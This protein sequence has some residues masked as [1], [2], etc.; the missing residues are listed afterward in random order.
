MKILVTGGA[1]YVGSVLVPYLLNKGHKVCVL[2]ILTHGINGLFGCFNNKNF[3][4]RKGDVRNGYEYREALAGSVDA[5]IHLAAVVGYP[6]CKQ[7]KDV[8]ISIN[9]HG[10]KV[11]AEET[12]KELPIIFASTGSVYG[13]IGD[14]CTEDVPINPLTIYGE[15]KG[16]AETMFKKRGNC[17]ILRF[18]TAYGVSPRMRLDLMINDFCYKAIHHNHLIVYERNFRRTFIHVYDMARA[19]LFAIENFDSMA[20][21]I[22]NVGS[23]NMN[24]TKKYIVEF[25]MQQ[26]PYYLHY[27]DIGEDEDKRD[28]AVSYEKIDALG[29]Q[30][31]VSLQ[32]GIDQLISLFEVW[33]IKSKYSNV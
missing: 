15:S 14:M 24:L 4:F 25:I 28:Y 23:K 2:D 19:F 22:Y 6:A 8:A 11:V 20:G 10:S 7:N 1:G 33:D 18:A 21:E 17:A 13:E 12:P 16:L 32:T 3:E 5:V 26:V 27:A 31:E 29:F 9:A 30:T